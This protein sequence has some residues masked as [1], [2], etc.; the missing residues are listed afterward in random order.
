M[1]VFQICEKF[2]NFLKKFKFFAIFLSN[3]IFA[4]IINFFIIASLF[5]EAF[6]TPALLYN[7][8]GKNNSIIKWAK[9]VKASVSLV[10]LLYFKKCQQYKQHP[11]CILLSLFS[12]SL[13]I[14]NKNFCSEKMAMATMSK[15]RNLIE[16]QGYKNKE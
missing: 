16:V 10:C 14:Q 15:G 3:K 6:K 11:V 5:R 13:L 7:K 8:G 9:I 2:K 1:L 4:K 12:Q